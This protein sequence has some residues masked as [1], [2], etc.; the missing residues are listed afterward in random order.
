MASWLIRV[1]VIIHL[2]VLLVKLNN[3]T[4]GFKAESFSESTILDGPWAELGNFGQKLDYFSYWFTPK[5]L[6]V[7]HTFHLKDQQV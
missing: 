1:M 3:F 5:F 2:W 7:T 6:M 4:F